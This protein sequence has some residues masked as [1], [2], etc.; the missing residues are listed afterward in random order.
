MRFYGWGF[1]LEE[2]ERPGHGQLLAV[3]PDFVVPCHEVRVLLCEFFAQRHDAPGVEVGEV[4]VS[5]SDAEVVDL[6]I[7]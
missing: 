3:R 4:A 7:D 1:A 2:G 6:C 5:D